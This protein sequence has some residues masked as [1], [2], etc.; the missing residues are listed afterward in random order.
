MDR[1]QAAAIERKQVW[2]NR[3]KKG[4]NSGEE[5][6]LAPFYGFVPLLSERS[7]LRTPMANIYKYSGNYETLKHLLPESFI[8]QPYSYC[9]FK[10]CEQKSR[11]LKG[12]CGLVTQS[13]YPFWDCRALHLSCYR[14]A[15]VQAQ[16]PYKTLLQDTHRLVCAR[17]PGPIRATFAGP[18]PYRED[19]ES[20]HSSS[21]H[22]SNY[23]Y[24]SDLEDF[25]VADPANLLA[26]E[27]ICRHLREGPLLSRKR[28]CSWLSDSE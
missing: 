1:I 11:E 12:V 4:A 7:E 27:K 6:T 14:K 2:L 23:A 26:D 19:S 28:D 10:D 17:A 5:R 22:G 3:S 24:E 9:T 15:S 20:L 18:S 21:S 16:D 25:V 8:D 13:R